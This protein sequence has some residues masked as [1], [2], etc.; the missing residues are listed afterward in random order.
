MAITSWDPLTEVRSLARRLERFMEPMTSVTSFREPFRYFGEGFWPNVD[1]YEDKEEIVCMVE[2]PGMDIKDVEI[3]L[4]DSTLTIQ[5]E[6]KMTR[7]DKKENYVRV[8]ANYG[9]FSRSFTMPSTIDKDRIRA[10]FKNGV[11]EIHLPKR[12]EAKGRTIPIHT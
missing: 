6:R 12:A 8:E 9:S 1:I 3:R 5:G 4:E 10:E 11:L 2:L 7:E